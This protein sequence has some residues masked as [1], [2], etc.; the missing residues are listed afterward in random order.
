MGSSKS[1][2]VVINRRRHARGTRHAVNGRVYA[3]NEVTGALH[4]TDG[5]I[6]SATAGCC[7]EDA[8]RLLQGSNYRLQV[9]RPE[10]PAPAA[11][12]QAQPE[13]APVDLESVSAAAPLDVLDQSV[14]KITAA[15][16]TGE[17]DNHLSTLLDAENGGKTRKSAVLAIQERITLL[18]D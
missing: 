5:E 12:S 14:S 11:R 8:E 17:Y 15:L 6:V 10:P 4:L 2:I 9:E 18:E 7:Q 16:K 13:V 3:V 1:D